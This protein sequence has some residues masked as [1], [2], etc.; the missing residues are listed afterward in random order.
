MKKLI[1]L[2]LLSAS[3]IQATTYTVK[4]SGGDFTSI[5][6]CVNAMSASGGDTCVAYAGTDAAAVITMKAGASPNVNTLVVNTGD[7]VNVW[8]FVMAS[9][10]KVQG[11]TVTR[12]ASPAGNYCFQVPTGTSYA[13]IVSNTLFECGTGQ[14]MIVSP[15]SSTASNHIYI[16]NNTMSFGCGTPAAPNPCKG[17]VAQ[18]DHWL[19]EGNNATRIAD[20]L[21]LFAH[22]SVIRNNNYHDILPECTATHGSNCHVDFVESE[23]AVPSEPPSKHNLFEGNTV[24]RNWGQQPHGILTQGDACGAGNCGYAIQRFNL[25]ARFGA[26]TTGQGQAVLDDLANYPYVKT[27]NNTIAYVVQ[28]NNV[29]SEYTGGSTTC[30]GAS[31]NNI[32]YYA[33]TPTFSTPYTPGG[34]PGFTARSNLG[35]CE[36]GNTCSFSSPWSSGVGNIKV[37]PQFVNITADNFNLQS[38]SP[39]RQAGSY[40]TTAVGSGSSS[41]ALTVADAAYFYDGA[42]GLV[43]ADWI[44]IGPTNVAQICASDNTTN[45]ITLCAPTSWNSG[46]GVYLY[47]DSSGNVQLNNTNPDIGAFQ[48]VGGGGGSSGA[49]LAP[50]SLTF[51]GQNVGTTSTGQTITLTSNGSATLNVSNITVSGPFA[52]SGGTCVGTAFALAVGNS[53]TLIITFTPVASGAAS[54]SLQV[55]DDAPG[56]PQSATLTGTGLAPTPSWNISSFVFSGISV[57]TSATQTFTLSN[58]GTA[59]LN[60]ALTFTGSAAFTQQSTTCGATLTAGNSC[61]VTVKFTPTAQAV[62]TGSLI[63]T[64]STYGLTVNVAL[65]GNGVITPAVTPS[66]FAWRQP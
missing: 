33:T 63:E 27:Y 20:F 4:T 13:Y 55:F 52:R 57:T 14:Y 25:M 46:D 31:I 23:P 1:I 2:A 65:S 24:M 37:D 43:N 41:T 12:P 48:F 49:T 5:Q 38:T 35:F 28:Q 56:S 53:C 66:I 59:T 11:F 19:I 32:Y 36:G 58:V 22:D 50:G 51:A 64:D 30:C 9:W 21:T 34:S 29:T 60:V 62:Y 16:Q 45:I 40:L 54:G 17:I 26:E 61:T 18:G 42:G 7:T 47:K 8:G 10:S 39:A 15:D 6:T 3:S 44:R